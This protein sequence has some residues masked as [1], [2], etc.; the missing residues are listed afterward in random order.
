MKTSQVSKAHGTTHTHQSSVLKE[1][2][3]S[4]AELVSDIYGIT[5]MGMVVVVT[6]FFMPCFICGDRIG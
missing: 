2:L 6:C 5:S 4:M 1:G 3:F